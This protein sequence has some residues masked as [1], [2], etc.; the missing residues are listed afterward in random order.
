M[1]KIY[2]L[3]GIQDLIE[4]YARI[5][6]EI[7]KVDVEVINYQLKRV[8]GTGFFNKFVGDDISEWGEVYKHVIKTGKRQIITDPRENPLCTH[9]PNRDS[10][11]ET[12]E[13]STPIIVDGDVLGVIG[14]VCISEESKDYVLSNLDSYLEYLDQIADFISSKVVEVL[15]EEDKKA[16]VQMLELI[17]RN[18]DQGALIIDNNNNIELINQSAK[19]Q[20]GIRRI[21]EK[22][23]IDIEE[24]GDTVNNYKEFNL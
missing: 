12:L 16:M 9:C 7:A 8:A 18:M 2:D 13:I 11:V 4:K 23:R 3:F 19:K 15:E 20:L 24:T 5:T 22:E 1:V 10:C 6:A 17:L 21:I 14:M